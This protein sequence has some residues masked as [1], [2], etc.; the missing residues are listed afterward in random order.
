MT[1]IHSV[2]LFRPELHL[3]WIIQYIWFLLILLC[4]NNNSIIINIQWVYEWQ[5]CMFPWLCQYRRYVVIT[6]NALLDTSFSLTSM[7]VKVNEVH[8]LHST[9]HLLLAISRHFMLNHFVPLSLGDTFMRPC[10][11]TVHVIKVLN[12]I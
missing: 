2:G 6:V 3:L 8:M 1:C 4:I 11:L 7:T 5:Q 9:I 10:F 12:F